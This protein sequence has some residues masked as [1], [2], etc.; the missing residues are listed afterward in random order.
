MLEGKIVVVTGSAQGIGKHAARTF[1]EQKAKVVI[2][3]FNEELAG[4]T[5]AELGQFTETLAAP[6][7]VREEVSVKALVDRVIARFGQIDVMVN[8]AAIVPHFAWG[9]PRWPRV[10]AMP[11]EFWDRVIRTNLYGTFYGTKHVLPH[12][13]KRKSGHVINLYGGGGLTP[14]GACAYMASK[15]AIR[16]FT[17]YVA[18][19]V[20]DAN[21]C[22]VIFSPRVPIVTESAPAEAF[23]RLPG[24][25]ILGQGFVLA[26]QLALDRSGEIFSYQAGKLVN[27]A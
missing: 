9:I 25:E 1:A 10:A 18:E 20:R 12:M 23:K 15:D 11:M 27:E 8:N 13:E 3:D 6:V 21:V 22:V 17:R 19:E 14:A 5:A 24:P 4:K 2:A 26:A 7:D 16:A